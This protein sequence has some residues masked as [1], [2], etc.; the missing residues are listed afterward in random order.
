MGE[1]H[2]QNAR[3]RLDY[4]LI[5]GPIFR[6]LPY[7]LETILV[8]VY[9]KAKFQGME[10]FLPI[11]LNCNILSKNEMI[12]KVLNWKNQEKKESSNF[13]LDLDEDLIKYSLQ[14]VNTLLSLYSRMHQ[15]TW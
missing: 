15:P 13:H 6:A 10:L 14:D 3:A 4:H 11:L 7:T 9:S 12:L 8:C 1:G 2:S 5:V